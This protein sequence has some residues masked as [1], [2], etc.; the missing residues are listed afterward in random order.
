MAYSF[1]TQ[2]YDTY[3][4]AKLSGQETTS[5]DMQIAQALLEMCPSFE[6]RCLVVDLRE[7]AGSLSIA[8]NYYLAREIAALCHREISCMAT[9]SRSEN[10][11]TE[12]FF[13]MALH[14][15]GVSA[16]SFT[17][18]ASAENWIKRCAAHI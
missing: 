9:V 1:E 8:D 14:N 12:Q 6:K 3:L 11:Q 16:E 13:A 17:D 18:L 15:R 5:E 10:H 4:Y 7:L 2:V